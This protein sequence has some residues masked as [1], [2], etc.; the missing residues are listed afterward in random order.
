MLHKKILTRKN[1]KIEKHQG[2]TQQSYL[3]FAI[4]K[5][6]LLCMKI[7]LKLELEKHK[8]VN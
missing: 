4:W 6:M 1:K 7:A 5:T 8:L 2:A 3:S